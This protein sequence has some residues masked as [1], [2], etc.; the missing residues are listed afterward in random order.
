MKTIQLLALPALTAMLI[1]CGGGGGGNDVTTA[2]TTGASTAAPAG[3]N[4]SLPPGT[5]TAVPPGTNTAATS[6]TQ[7]VYIDKY[8]GVWETACLTND[9]VN[10]SGRFISTISKKSDA[11]L[12]INLTATRFA[13]KTCTGSSLRPIFQGVTTDNTYVNTINNLDRFIYSGNGKSTL[14]ITGSILNVGNEVTPDAAGYPII[15]FND[16]ET[17]FTKK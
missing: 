5:N 3:A 15:D 2:A 17:A 12:T 8:V 4:T 10:E 13:G 6:V 9:G 1:A 14:K 11:V 7:T 16:L